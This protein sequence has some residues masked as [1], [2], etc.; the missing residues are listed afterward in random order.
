MKNLLLLCFLALSLQVGAQSDADANIKRG[1]QNERMDNLSPDQ[2][3]ELKAK[4]LAL[5]LDLSDAQHKEVLQ[6][7]KKWE[8]NQEAMRKEMQSG[9]E[10]TKDQRFE[11]KSKMLDQEIE[12]KKQL[13]SILTEAQYA[14]FEETKMGQR[15]NRKHKQ[16][17]KKG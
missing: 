12:M 14:K 13:K 11:H 8:Q 5:H 15:G 2:R 9:K 1:A 4:K 17:N 3:A 10:I 16:K 7:S 6:L